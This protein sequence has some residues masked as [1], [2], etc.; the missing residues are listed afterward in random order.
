VGL[1]AAGIAFEDHAPPGA[2]GAPLVLVHGS[3]GSGAQWPQ[4]LR[5]LPGRRVLALDLPGHGASPPPPER[6]VADLARRVLSL[7]DALSVPRAV[8]AGHSLGGAVALETAL[9]APERVAGLVLVGTGARL[10]VTPAILEAAADPARSGEVARA[11]AAVSFG[12]AA[13]PALAAAYAAEIAACP[14]GGV[15][16]DLAACDAFDVM[17]R[18]GVLSAPTLVISGGEDRLTP[19]R[20]AAFLA[21]GIRSARLATV[22][23]AGHML[24][25][26]APGPLV[27]EVAGFLASVS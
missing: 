20:Y 14:P 1:T 9:A 25:S 15:H 6:S 10:R 17:E 12:P 27:L 4:A 5:R 2:A 23:G 3:G 24:L 16:A 21:S 19:P 8:V 22:P 18:L 7:L 13:P 11:V 26:E